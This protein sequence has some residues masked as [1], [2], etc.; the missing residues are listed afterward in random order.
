LEP[1]KETYT[2]L[3]HAYE[4]RGMQA[5]A[6]MIEEKLKRLIVPAGRP[7]RILRPRRVVI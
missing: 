3:K 6:D 1:N 5:E 4:E 7:R 2:L